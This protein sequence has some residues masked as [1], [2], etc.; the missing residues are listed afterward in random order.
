MLTKNYRIGELSKILGVSKK[1][2][3][4]WADN[5]YIPQPHRDNTLM[6]GRY[7]T[8]NEAKEIYLYKE[9]SYRSGN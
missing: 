5:G 4:Y 9:T 2:L 1:T 3:V 6:S 7:W 8:E